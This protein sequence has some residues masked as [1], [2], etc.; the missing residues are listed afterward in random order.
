VKLIALVVAATMWCT[1]ALSQE[2]NVTTTPAA[3]AIGYLPLFQQVTTTTSTIG[4][5]MV[6]QNGL[7][8]GATGIGIGTKVP[9]ATLDVNGSTFV[10]GPLTLTPFIMATAPGS[11]GLSNSLYFTASV[12]N[13]ST[14]RAENESFYWEVV[15]PNT[16]SAPLASQLVLVSNTG[17]AQNPGPQ[18]NT[19]L[20]ISNTGAVTA[21]GAVTAPLFTATNKAVGSSAV[22]GNNTATSGTGT[23]GGSFYSS[24]PQG[25]AVV[26]VNTSGGVAG[27]FHGPVT[28]TGV[29]TT[30][31]ITVTGGSDLAEPFPILGSHVPP[32]AVVII[33]ENR[34]GQLKLSE[35]AYDTRVAGIVSGANGILPGIS[36][37]QKG[38]L[39]L[40]R[41][42]A[43]SGRVYALADACNGAIKPGDLLTTSATPGYAMKVTDFPKAQGAILGKAMT[44]LVE[45]EG[46]VLVLVTLQ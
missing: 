16:S 5:S 17:T 38:N 11:G 24:S 19:L 14:N 12:W 6:I 37:R 15:P 8:T 22:V 39:G 46:V 29:T 34:P 2:V 10:E 1:Y 23:N 25:A 31:A 7:S 9:N 33:D 35:H 21:Y 32:G 43:L 40:G 30:G 42:V 20:S 44:G 36:M 41:N 27:Y 18:S 45:G 28:V 13:S 3:D 26:G 4:N